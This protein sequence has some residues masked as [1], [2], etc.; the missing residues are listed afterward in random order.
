MLV[1]EWIRSIKDENANALPGCSEEEIVDALVADPS[2]I[3]LNS[4]ALGAMAGE[5][6]REYLAGEFYFLLWRKFG[7]AASER[8][9]KAQWGYG[10]PEWF[11]HRHHILEPDRWC[12]DYWA[13]SADNVLRVL[14]LGGRLLNLC[15]GDGFYDYYFYRKRA[16]DIVCVE[17]DGSAISQARRLHLDPR[18]TLIEADVLSYEPPSGQF[19]VVAIRGAIE[20]FGQAEQQA[21]FQKAHQALKPDGWFCGDTVQRREDGNK[22][23]TFHEFEWADER[24]MAAE[25]GRVFGTVETHTMVSKETT[26]LFW[27]CRKDA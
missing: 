23:L 11:D 4:A 2:L 8:L 5:Q 25:L 21:I 16:E 3:G 26:T 1:P 12:T 14:P 7:R 22:H 15:S 17:R 20:H 27:R 13:E 10:S 24:E 19:D 9:F 18:I 6:L